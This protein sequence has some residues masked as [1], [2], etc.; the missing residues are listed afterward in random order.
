[1]P[2][3]QCTV[4]VLALDEAALVHAHRRKLFRHGYFIDGPSFIDQ[5]T[6]S[7]RNAANGSM[8]ISMLA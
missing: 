2:D 1:M 5:R 7:A 4:Q 6:R 3:C 8:F